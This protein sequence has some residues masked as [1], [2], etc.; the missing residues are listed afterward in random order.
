MGSLPSIPKVGSWPGV[1]APHALPAI[2]LRKSSGNP[3]TSWKVRTAKAFEFSR[4]FWIIRRLYPWGIC[5]QECKV[6]AKDGREI[7][8][9][10][11][12]SIVRND[13]GHVAGAIGTFTDLTAFIVNNQKIA[14]LEEQ[15]K[16]REAFQKLIGTSPPMQEVF[17]QDCDWR[18][19]AT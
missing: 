1:P 4:I 7:Y 5:N 13:Q 8:L 11:N 10:G 14:V 3:A 9:Y 15:T 6:L 17:R 12:V 2:P 19:K 18:L 16:S